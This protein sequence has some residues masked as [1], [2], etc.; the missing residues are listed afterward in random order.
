MK[1]LIL[2][3][4]EPWVGTRFWSLYR[5]M[6]ARDRAS[7]V[8]PSGLRASTDKLRQTRLLELLRHAGTTVSR[9]ERIFAE[10]GLQPDK[11]T[12]E[13]AMSALRQLP[14]T[15]KQDYKE[16][17]PQEVT[18]DGTRDQWRYAHSAGTTDRLTMVNDFRRRDIARAVQ[19]RTLSRICDRDLGTTL[20]EL[21]PN[22]CNVVCGIADSG[23][24]EL[25]PFLWWAWRRGKLFV[26]ETRAD[27]RGR[28]ERRLVLDRHTLLPIEPRPWDSL[29]EELDQ[30]LD[31]IVDAKPHILRG[32]PIYLVWLA[33]RALQRELKIPNL[34]AVLPFGG[35]M[36]GQMAGRIERAFQVPFLD[37][38]GTGEV[39]E[40][41]CQ[42]PGQP[43]LS[44]YDDLFVVEIVDDEGQPVGPGQRG[45]I[46]VTDLMN[47]AMPIIRYAIGDIGEEISETEEES[48][49]GQR[50]ARG[51][52]S[53]P[54][55]FS[56]VKRMLVHGRLQERLTVSSGQVVEARE[57]LDVLFGHPE[58][59]NGR[60]DEQSPG[61]FLVKVVMATSAPSQRP[62]VPQELIQDLQALFGP[63]SQVQV[64]P[65]RLLQPEGSGKYRVAFAAT[66]SPVLSTRGQSEILSANT[67]PEARP[68]RRFQ[69][70]AETNSQ[71]VGDFRRSADSNSSE[72][73]PS[74]EDVG[75]NLNLPADHPATANRSRPVGQN[76]GERT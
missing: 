26:P 7:S 20:V 68:P 63:Q 76:I 19:L 58:V 72:D 5:Q 25:V 21:P 39:G 23:P 22:A 6:R 65:A 16:G 74:S 9:W 62:R 52:T 44:I 29:Q 18:S 61:R 34:R 69:T 57:L 11:L 13:T 37:V 71:P 43:G 31:A 54:A 59:V 33:E 17:F 75:V 4:L 2:S 60:V 15:T 35:L 28:I 8:D 3:I 38:Y 55:A 42:L 24:Q 45:R 64:R 67:T 10:V 40:L 66:R 36:S 27:I 53:T 30:R 12:A 46:V 41:A 48:S 73:S 50:A 47:R 70:Q 56:A 51:Q 14:V 1:S 32:L 49:A